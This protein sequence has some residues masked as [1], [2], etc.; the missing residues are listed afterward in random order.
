[1]NSLTCT[2]LLAIPGRS[3]PAQRR[4][5]VFPTEKKRRQKKEGED[6]KDPEETQRVKAIKK[7]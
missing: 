6:E 2:T 1:M 3:Y 4:R 5:A 7:P